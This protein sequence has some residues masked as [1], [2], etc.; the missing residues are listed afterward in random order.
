[1]PIDAAQLL[2][3]SGHECDTVY[4][5]ELSG[6]NSR[7]GEHAAHRWPRPEYGITLP[8]MA[9]PKIKA[10]YSLDT[11]TVRLLE[12]LA[13][14][15][16]V[17]KSEALRRLIRASAGDAPVAKDRTDVVDRW[18]ASL[19]LTEAVAAAWARHARDERRASSKRR[20][21]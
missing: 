21:F 19:G 11:E 1:M 2:R 15:W 7:R 17:S 8:G 10:T 16:D 14:Q 3:A 18:Q 13:R 12:R 9:I 5:E 4:D 20:G 6:T